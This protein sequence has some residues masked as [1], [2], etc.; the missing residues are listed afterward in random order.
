MTNSFKDQLATNFEKA[1]NAG[2]VRVERIRQI[3]QDAVTQTM[4]ELKEGT[5]EMRS[6]AKESTSTL[7]E[8]LK[9]PQKTAV[10]TEVIP[11]QVE[12]Q[13]DGVEPTVAVVDSAE[14]S[15]F[16]AASTE[17]HISTDVVQP[18]A[19]EQAASQSSTSES[20]VDS[21]KTLIE[22]AL[23]SFK[24]GATYANLQQQFAKIK[25][26]LAVL[27]VKLS[28][29][30]GERYK[31]TKQ[32]FNQDMERT[33]AWYEEMKENANTSGM[34]LLEYK[35]AELVIKM[36]EAGMT[37]AQKEAKIK[38]LLKELWQTASKF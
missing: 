10:Q 2:S 7:T 24:E 17:V 20:L 6:I 19:D 21:L 38:Q 8:N 15:L 16:D 25:E 12:I 32:E 36:S 5:G 13:D 23:R 30:F 3:F 18:Q 29:R 14:P 4:T 28:E 27:D 26:Q 11:V 33:K 1:K 34:N 9:Q 31:N 35:Q 22:Q 37:I